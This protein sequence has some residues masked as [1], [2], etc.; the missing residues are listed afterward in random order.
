MGRDESARTVMKDNEQAPSG[1]TQSASPRYQGNERDSGTSAPSRMQNGEVEERGPCT[2]ENVG[3][4]HVVMMISDFFYPRLGG[5]EMHIWSLAQCLLDRGHKVVVVTNQYGKRAGVR[6]MTNGLKVYYMPQLPFCEQASFPSLVCFLPYLRQIIV[7]EGVTIVH[8]HQAT[9]TMC[10]E[11]LF[12]AK[13]LGLPTVYTD[14]SLYAFGDLAA[15]NVNKLMKFSL[16]H[17]DHAIC[18]SHTWYVHK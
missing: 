14:H 18:V 1:P 5:V 15:I 4:G 9:S 13:V 10:H 8:G 11:N 2:R 7:R 17:V 6:Y 16:S 3:E 12:S